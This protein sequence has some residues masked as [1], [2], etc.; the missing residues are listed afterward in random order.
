MRL[1]IHLLTLPQKIYNASFLDQY[2]VKFDIMS[3]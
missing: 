2:R 3:L 1:F